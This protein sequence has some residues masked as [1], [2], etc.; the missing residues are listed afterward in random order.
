MTWESSSAVLSIST[1]C[2]LSTFS[3]VLCWRKKYQRSCSSSTKSAVDHLQPRRV[4]LSQKEELI[5]RGVLKKGK[6]EYPTL[7]DV[8]SDW[9]T[10]NDDKG[11][12]KK[13]LGSETRSMSKEKPG[14]PVNESREGI[15]AT[16]SESREKNSTPVSREALEHSQPEYQ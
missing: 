11:S 12:Q 13:V 15:L 3:L 16:A 2:F 6:H 1:L 8:V 10:E 14:S 4:P 9:S 7:D 5:A